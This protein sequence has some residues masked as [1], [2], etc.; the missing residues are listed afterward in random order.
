[1][2]SAPLLSP[3]R[4][5]LV[6]AASVVLLLVSAAVTPMLAVG[7][8]TAGAAVFGTVS[9]I[10]IAASW[11]AP[12]LPAGSW[13]SLIW[14]A[15]PVVALAAAA[16]LRAQLPPLAF[17]CIVLAA[18]MGAGALVGGAVGSQVEHAGYLVLIGWIAA[19]VDF[20]SVLAPSGPTAQLIESGEAVLPLVALSWPMPGTGE[21][22]PVLG[23]G[24]VTMSALL[25]Q[26][27]RATRLS[28]PRALLGLTLG[29][30]LTFTLLVFFRRP[31]PALPMLGA[32]VVLALAPASLRVP[33]EDR[34]KGIG[35]ALVVTVV[36]VTAVVARL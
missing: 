34:V 22:A 27:A 11:A 16:A 12:G 28:V 35:F 19:V 36:S 33:E 26:A 18:L 1:M 31:L 32:G 15:V 8:L 7:N 29:F 5:V 9:A 6:C 20:G 30:V 24:D 13:R 17:A 14:V 23:V 3:A 21:L 25:V 2:T 4:L 10:V